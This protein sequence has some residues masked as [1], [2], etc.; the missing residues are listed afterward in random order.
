MKILE[1]V[2]IDSREDPE[3]ANEMI[4]KALRKLKPFA[5]IEYGENVSQ[6]KIEKFLL[7]IRK[8]YGLCCSWIM[9]MYQ[10][11]FVVYSATLQNDMPLRK[12]MICHVYGT[13]MYEVLCKAALR[14][15]AQI[16]LDGLGG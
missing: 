2:D 5:K 12:G 4:Q 9:P 16:K 6:E 3:F 8:K 15:W 7:L 14:L 13:S 1:I 11:D 10:E